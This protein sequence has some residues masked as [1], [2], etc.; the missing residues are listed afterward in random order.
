M[1]VF[2]FP[3]CKMS[4]TNLSSHHGL[5]EVGRISPVL[6]QDAVRQ[7][8][9]RNE[10]PQFGLISSEE[11]KS[12]IQRYGT[13][14]SASTRLDTLHCVRNVADCDQS[15]IGDG[16]LCSMISQAPICR[17]FWKAGKYDDIYVSKPTTQCIAL[18]KSKLIV[19][20]VLK[21]EF[22]TVAYL[23]TIIC[24]YIIGQSAL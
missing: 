7:F 10:Y 1:H 19:L 15:P 14:N 16:S 4:Y 6:E 24:C 11:I 18:L 17:E 23:K 22:H 2:A 20:A 21:M 8:F 5:G 12:L 9:H 13:E 3:V